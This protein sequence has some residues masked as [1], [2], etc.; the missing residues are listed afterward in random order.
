MEDFGPD[1]SLGCNFGTEGQD[2]MK[3]HVQIYDA[4]AKLT[5]K[6]Y[7]MSGDILYD[8]RAKRSSIACRIELRAATSIYSISFFNSLALSLQVLAPPCLSRPTVTLICPLPVPKV[9]STY[10]MN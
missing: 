6:I 8:V 4:A 7:D 1:T 2:D 9:S 10:Q 5:E 3:K